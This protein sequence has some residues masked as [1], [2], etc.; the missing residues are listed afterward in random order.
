VPPPERLVSKSAPNST[1]T[2]YP[3]GSK[4]TDAELAAIAIELHSFHGE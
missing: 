1:P 4:V 3:A 2:T